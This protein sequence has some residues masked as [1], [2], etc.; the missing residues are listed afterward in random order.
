MSLLVQTDAGIDGANSYVT[1]AEFRTYH[2]DRGTDV[3]IYTDPQIEKALVKAT[4]YLDERFHFVGDRIRPA[5]RTAWPRV[6]AVDD[7]GW[8]RVGIPAEVKEACHEYALIAL[9]S[10]LNLAPTLDASGRV[11]QSK[12]ST[13]GPITESVTY[14]AG[15]AFKMPKY[16]KAD[17]RLSGLTE[18]FGT[19]S[20]G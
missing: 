1:V 4:D 12:T 8:P 15:A 18:S 14:A 10:E 19:V 13:V 7:D 16:P 11:V 20:R 17:R 3:A 9:T 6:S 5:Q 2:A